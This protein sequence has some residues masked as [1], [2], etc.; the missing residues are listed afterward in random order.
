[1][2]SIAPAARQC[3]IGEHHESE[4]SVNLQLAHPNP[5]YGKVSL[6]EPAPLGY[7]HIGAEVRPSARPGPVV[8]SRERSQLVGGLKVLGRQVRPPRVPL[9]RCMRLCSLMWTA[10]GSSAPKG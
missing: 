7:L 1:V 9:R 5:A 8:P 6:I 10:F 4:A 2:I 3:A